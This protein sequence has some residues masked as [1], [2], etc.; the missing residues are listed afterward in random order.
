VEA[1]L[2]Q[3]DSWRQAWTAQANLEDAVRRTED[4]AEVAVLK[5]AVDHLKEPG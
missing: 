5:A 2:A 4:P 3:L 1:E